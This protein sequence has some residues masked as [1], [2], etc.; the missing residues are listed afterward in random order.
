MGNNDHFFPL[1]LLIISLDYWCWCLCIDVL[2]ILLVQI[3]G[4]QST[5]L[6]SNI[7]YLSLWFRQKTRQ[8]HLCSSQDGH[9]I[10]IV[11]TASTSIT[12]CSGHN[13][14]EPSEYISTDLDKFIVSNVAFCCKQSDDCSATLKTLHLW[15]VMDKDKPCQC[16]ITRD[17]MTHCNNGLK[18]NI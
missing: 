17:S 14:S 3:P 10:C 11:S 15:V 1:C 2:R 16:V 12:V 18:P 7:L 6:K 13:V 9:R 5:T 8:W 4:V